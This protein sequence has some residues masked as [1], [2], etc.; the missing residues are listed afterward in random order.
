MNHFKKL[1]GIL[2]LIPISAHAYDFTWYMQIGISAYEE[3]IETNI[4]SGEGARS[5]VGLK[6]NDFIGFEMNI[7]RANPTS[8]KDLVE[9]LDASSYSIK[10]V[11]NRYISLL[12]TLT[13]PISDQVALIGKVGVSY[14][15]NSRTIEVFD[16]GATRSDRTKLA[17][18]SPV[19]SA[20]LLFS[21]DKKERHQ[22]EV[23]ITRFNKTEVQATA[24]TATWR[25]NFI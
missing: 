15:R 25:M 19:V 9:I 20:G 6:I 11:S 17:G 13:R 8:P 16:V 5:G 14:Y 12:T 2:L 3:D 24:L 4:G 23:S 22:L 18:I 10:T 21:F 1:A 7:D